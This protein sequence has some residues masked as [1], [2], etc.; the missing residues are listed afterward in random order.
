[1]QDAELI[2]RSVIYV[3]LSL[4]AGLFYSGVLLLSGMV[5]GDQFRSTRQT[6]WVAGLTG[7]VML[8]VLELAKKR[9]QNVIDR[10]F[11]LE[12]YNSDQAMGKMRVAVGSMVDRATLALRLLEAAPQV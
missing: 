7:C 10:Q 11:F 9:F 2:N 1:M 5:I 8:A 6:S 4:M 3:A 12:K